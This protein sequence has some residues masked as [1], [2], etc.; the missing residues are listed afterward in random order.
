VVLKVPFTQD[1][2]SRGQFPA[3]TDN[4]WAGR[5]KGA[6]FDQEFYLIFNVAVGGVSGYFPD[7]QGGKPWNDKSPGTVNQFW[8]ARNA[9]H[10]TWKGEDSAL[11]IDWVR[12][13]QD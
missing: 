5:G 3:G 11:Q 12:V 8:A 7:G 4:P 6:P 1:F 13:S 2:F 9:W 10:P